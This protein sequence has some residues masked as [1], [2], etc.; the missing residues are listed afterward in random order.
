M[1]GKPAE[2]KDSSE[3]RPS[4]IE[5]PTKRLMSLDALR[6]FD[7]AFIVGG[8]VILRSFGEAI[9]PEAHKWIVQQTTHPEWHGYSAWDQIFPLFMFVSGVAMPFA[10][11]RRIESGTSRRE[12]AWKVVR[13]GLLLILLGFIYNRILKLDLA[14]QRYPSVLGRIGLG[15]LFAGLIVLSTKI[16]GQLIWTLGIL[17]GYCLALTCVPVPGFGAGDL[18]PGHTIADYVDRLL[19]PGKLYHGDRDPEGLFSTLPAI[20][21][22][23]SGALAGHWL[24]R[25]DLSGSKKAA[26]LLGGGVLCVL[27]GL[28]WNSWLPF[29]K[30]L[31][32][33]SFVLLTSGI[34]LALLALFYYVID[35]QRY[36]RWAFFFVVIGMNAI[37]IYLLR[38]FVDIEGIG[39]TLFAVAEDRVHPA[40]FSASEL[41]TGWLILYVLYRR[42]IFLR[43]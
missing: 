42:K 31:W 34:S 2:A 39:Q 4:L 14:N 11:T 28:V 29:N 8:S 16:R 27:L 33:S 17:I 1:D 36:R 23:L 9:G 22:V 21:T 5:P 32:S 6:G 38:K 13:R 40:I 10:L 12:L 25:N 37:T 26:G 18:Q 43:V 24:R 19:V 20:A 30:N 41:F 15:Y 7:M 3:L 35:V